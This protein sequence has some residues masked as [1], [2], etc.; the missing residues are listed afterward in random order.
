MHNRLQELTEKLYN[1]G[2]EKGRQEA[3]V[4]LAQTKE[5][6]KKKLQE[7][8]DK[9][10]AIVSEAKQ[11]AAEIERMAKDDLKQAAK[12]TLV[13][14]QQQVEQVVLQKT[15]DPGVNVAGLDADF[16]EKALVSA[17]QAWN[18]KA[19]EPVSLSILLP[20]AL[21]NQ[22]EERFKVGVHAELMKGMEIRFTSKMSGGFKIGPKDGSYYV[23][24]SS[25]DF[26]NLFKSYLRPKMQ[27]Y[28]F[29]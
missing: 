21:Q 8:E 18:P 27:T 4:L 1:E 14:V 3:E 15:I 29:E 12:N 6:I 23:S 16:I 22:L 24:F 13:T 2:L 17:I 9:A 10:N 26:S 28:L 20:A 19:S 7:A 5:Q 11:Q 25:A